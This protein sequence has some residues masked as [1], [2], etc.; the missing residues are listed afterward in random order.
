MIKIKRM[1]GWLQVVCAVVLMFVLAA[2][3]STPDRPTVDRV[4]PAVKAAAMTGT[5]LVLREHPEWRPHFELAAQEL[6]VLTTA[7]QIDFATVL[8][9][10]LRLPV[11]ELQG[12]DAKLA[13]AGATILLSGYGDS[14]PLDKIEQ[15]RPIAKAL[16]DGIALGLR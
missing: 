11:K 4:V 1:A 10:V 15:V 8:N 7:E 16:A 12:D 5:V 3:Q 2:C 13:I 6:A 14:I 9:I